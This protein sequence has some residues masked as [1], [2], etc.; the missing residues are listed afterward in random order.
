MANLYI[1]PEIID[2]P[3]RFI[4]A[5]QMPA[6]TSPNPSRSE[7]AAE[8]NVQPWHKDE[9]SETTNGYFPRLDQG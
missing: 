2:M 8:I 5:V 1:R 7:C 4:C 6:Q 9:T 3:V